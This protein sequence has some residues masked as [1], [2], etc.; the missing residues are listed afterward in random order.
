MGKGKRLKQFVAYLLT[1]CMMVSC[2]SMTNM[3]NVQAAEADGTT[4]V[5]F[6]NSDGWTEVFAY[7]YGSTPSDALGGWPGTAATSAEDIGENW[8]KV[9]VPASPA[10]SIIFNNNNGEQTA[11]IYISDSSAIYTNKTDKY[12]SAEDAVGALAPPEEGGGEAGGE[13][14]DQ[15]ETITVYFYNSD[16]WAEVGA[17][18]CGSADYED[19]QALGD[20]GSARATA[21][22]IGENWMEVEV[23]SSPGFHLICYDVSNDGPNRIDLYVAN[24]TNIYGSLASADPYATKEEAENSVAETDVY[25]YNNQGWEEVAVHA[26]RTIE[27]DG[28]TSDVNLTAWPG[29][30]AEAVGGSW[31]KAT[32][33]SGAPFNVIFN[34]NDNDKQTGVAYIEN[35]KKVYVSVKEDGT[36]LNAYLSQVS[37]EVGIGVMDNATTMYFLN[38]KDWSSI[39]AYIWGD[40]GD[41]LGSW[42]EARMNDTVQDAPE[43][44]EKWKKILIP[45]KGNYNL[46]VFNRSWRDKYDEVTDEHAEEIVATEKERAELYIA[47]KSKVYLTGNAELYKTQLQAECAAGLIPEDEQTVVYFYNER[48]WEFVSGYT[49]TKEPGTELDKNAPGT[50]F[51][52]AWPGR[53]AVN[54]EDDLG[55]GWYKMVIP[56]IASETNPIFITI[57]DGANRT[58][59]V[60]ITS[61]NNNYVIPT[62]ELFTTQEA[63]EEAAENT[64]YEDGCE[65]GDNKDLDEIEYDA[66][67]ANLPYV[68]YEAEN[69]VVAESAEVLE[70]DRTYRDAIQSEASGRQA[71]VLDETGEY[72]EFELEEAANTMVLRYSI[73]DSA[74]GLGQDA[75]LSMSV[76]GGAAKKLNLTSKYSWLY[77]SYPFNNNVANGKPHRFYD[78]I[79]MMFDTTLPEGTIIR[80]EKAEDDTAEN[81]VI[82]FIECEEVGA[83]LTQPDGSLSVTD[84]AF[85]AVANDGQD[86]YAAFVACI[87][88][89]KE[90]GKEV[91]IPAG[92]FDLKEEK[93]LLVE[94]VNIR[95]AGMWYTNLVGAGVSFDFRGTCKFSDFAMTG[96]STVRDDGGDLAGFEP[97]ARSTNTT[98]ENIWMEHIKVGVWSA[99]TDNLLIQGCRIRNTWADGINLCSLTKNATVRNSNLRNTG[100]DCIAIWPW[101]N[102]CTGNTITHNT[103]QI[104]SL[105]NGIAI[106]GGGNNT[107]SGNHVMDTIGNGG[108]ICVGSEFAIRKPYHDTTTVVGN[109]LERCGSMQFDENYPIGAIWIWASHVNPMEAT[110]NVTENIIEDSSYNGIC[111]EVG[112]KLSGLNITDTTITGGEDGI[113]I[114]GN[115]KGSG[116]FDNIDISDVENKLV[117]NV[118]TNFSMTIGEAGI[119]NGDSEETYTPVA[120]IALDAEELE[121]GVEETAEL[122]ATVSPEG[123]AD[124]NITW[125]T[126]DDKVAKVKDGIVTGVGAGKATITATVNGISASCE[127][128]VVVPV[129]GVALDQ[130]TISL[131]KGATAT[132][133]ATITPENASNQNCDW[134][135]EDETIAT[136]EDGI[137]TAVGVGETTITVETKNGK[138]TA[139]C[140]VTVTAPILATSVTLSETTLSLEEGATQKLTA[141]VAPEDVT[142]DTV[143]WT[144]SNEEI[145]TVAEDGTVTAVKAG[146]AKITATTAN[147]IVASC[148][149]TVMAKKS[150]VPEEPKNPEEPKDPENPEEPKDPADKPVTVA[151]T[152]ITLATTAV[153]LEVGKTSALAAT[154]TPDNATDKT[155]TWTSSDEKVATVV[156][157]TVTA[158]APGKATITAKAGDKTATCEVTVK[159]PVI[160]VKSVKVS[161]ISKNLAVGT[162]VTMKATVTPGD[163]SVEKITWSIRDKDK[164][165]ASINANTGKLSIK[166]GAGKSI[167][168]YATVTGKDGKTVKSSGYKIT[169]KKHKVKKVTI[170]GKSTISVKYS[171]KKVQLKATVKTS[172]KSVNKKLKWTSSNTK[173]ATVNSKGKVTFKAAGKGKKVTITATATDGTGKKDKVTIRIKK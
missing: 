76:E 163:A 50:T 136:V 37:A 21:S 40:C 130:E 26:W 86:D 105:A 47:D 101:L 9:E 51:G 139:S 100:D 146:T 131:V 57:N 144:S 55:E 107:V 110:F 155:V 102:D 151:V 77:G 84:D 160:E 123:A 27:D 73:P 16:G 159:E 142:D 64:V 10:F 149:L 18:V 66:E 115:S 36:N 33:P 128:T 120:G 104:P 34:N 63:A 43:L 143:T 42:D 156:N 52:A 137:V 68:I 62:G 133:T 71:V 114:W 28:E 127:V 79:R 41:I 124:A 91:W 125:S 141:T 70:D 14:G 116:M 90:Q 157:G 13:T 148:D 7:V 135:T 1:F 166:K 92:T 111:V 138:F 45:E 140:T 96:V 164:K 117:N 78:E 22:D 167:I 121:I 23:P 122:I 168:V 108:G 89:A 35:S 97:G 161:A 150:D 24:T 103:V 87:K 46:I 32:I 113:Y 94:H 53:D 59:D 2:L 173:Y 61:V 38:N 4:T 11:D 171:K 165:Y 129:T 162:K 132:L 158:V 126:S 95:G 154:V 67:G 119:Y 58:E 99:N 29:V 12:A 134:I 74:D 8:W 80:L 31:Y 118:A 48:D 88:A 19:G 3:G 83:P 106:Y 169:I 6:Y 60:M 49:F 75:T 44:G 65:S 25:F 20:W 147:G 152:G 39:G 82:D 30:V 81:Y 145:A 172:G 153:E 56:D 15:T 72:V 109:Y 112:N 98:I 170:E 85:G 93:A 5:Y 69:A 17:Y 54:V